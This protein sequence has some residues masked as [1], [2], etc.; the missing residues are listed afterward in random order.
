MKSAVETLGPTRVKLTV[1]VPFDELKPNV[2]AAYKKIAQQ[3][4][5]PG[6]RKG[7]VPP[8]LIDQRIGRGA[9]LDEAVNEAVPRAYV[10]AL[11]E[12]EVEPLGQ[13]AVDLSEFADGQDLTFTAEVDVRP[14]I[15]VPD[16]EGLPVEVDGTE[17]TDEEVAQQLRDLQERFA[18]LATVERPADDEDHVT[19][20]LSAARGGEPIEDAQ[21]AGMSYQV[22]SGNLVDGLDDAVRGL[23]AGEAHTFQ[24]QLLAGEN[25]GEDADVTV[26]VQEVKEQELPE[27]DD[28]FAELA[29]SFDTLDE[30]RDDLRASLVRQK[31]LEQS[32]QARDKVLRQLLDQAE[33]PLPEQAVEGEIKARQDAVDQQLSQIGLSKEQYVQ[34]Q[35]QT[36]EEYD[37]ELDRGVREAMTSEFFLDRVARQAEIAVNE[38]EL[39]QHVV[40]RAQQARVDP[41]AY[42]QQVVQEGQMQS[43]VRE[44]ARTKALA[45][46][47]ES[48]AIT[49]SAGEPVDL[50]RLQSDGSLAPEEDEP[51]EQSLEGEASEGQPSGS[52]PSEGEQAPKAD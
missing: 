26:T 27:L 33:I 44:V 14:T 7:K 25:P 13:P 48:T 23:S 21:A 12:N 50:S 18:T 28:E 20:D 45:H 39:T 22:G 38:G 52:E 8:Q 37:A 15:T 43:L 40:V 4:N 29:S 2:D 5:L 24:T 41:N 47:V 17:V 9:V 16:Y 3:V 34:S 35:G 51:A 19:I 6:F 36:V 1:E 42:A 46:L 11:Q 49:D 30:L 10:E 31:R 32:Q